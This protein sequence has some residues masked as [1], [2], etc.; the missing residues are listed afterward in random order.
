MVSSNCFSQSL[1][2]LK[3]DTT[4]SS[5]NNATV[6]IAINWHKDEVQHREWERPISNSAPHQALPL[7]VSTFDIHFDSRRH[8]DQPAWPTIHC[9]CKPKSN[10]NNLINYWSVHHFIFLI[11]KDNWR[12]ISNSCPN[13]YSSNAKIVF[14]LSIIFSNEFKTLCKFSL[15]NWF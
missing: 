2:L 9:S 7:T 13:H 15:T 14:G 1:N 12:G 5:K 11:Y 10:V 4:Y 8:L 3:V 6:K